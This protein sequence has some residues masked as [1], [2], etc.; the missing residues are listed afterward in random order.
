MELDS[1]PGARKI[2]WN[3]LRGA[4]SGDPIKDKQCSTK[5]QTN[6]QMESS[7][8]RRAHAPTSHESVVL[9]RSMFSFVVFFVFLYIF[10]VFL[11]FII[12]ITI[13]LLLE[14]KCTYPLAHVYSRHAFSRHIWFSGKIASHWWSCE[15]SLFVK[16]IP[17][18]PWAVLLSRRGAARLTPS[19][20]K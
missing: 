10:A 11:P 14:C 12:H 9:A 18:T 17:T 15:R 6:S 7:T 5:P 1:L 3:P 4:S 13:I 20:Q 16:N 2:P 8:H 19:P